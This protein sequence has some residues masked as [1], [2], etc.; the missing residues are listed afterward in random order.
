MK[1]FLPSLGVL[2]IPMLTQAQ[3]L[4]L[5]SVIQ[6]LNGTQRGHHLIQES[7]KV[8]KL[9]TSTELLEKL[10]WGEAS[11][12]DTVLT[13]HYN[14]V[15]GAEEREQR[16]KIFLKQ[17]QTYVEVALDFAHE[18]V[19]AT[20]PSL[21]DPYDPKLTAAQY[22][23]TAI[24][25][26]GGEVEAVMA[27]CEVGFELSQKEPFANQRCQHY[28][29]QQ[30]LSRDRVLKDFYQVGKWLSDL[31]LRLGNEM[32]ILPR[33]SSEDPL[34]YSSTAHSP[35]PYA[36]LKEFEAI[37]EMACKNSK[38]RMKTLHSDPLASGREVE[39]LSRRCGQLKIL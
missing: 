8:W 18:L 21:F 3:D 22:I 9:R 7:L 14:P 31:A 27:E 20:H 33:L 11:R 38:I 25:G 23:R 19:H 15:T 34:L 29:H 26:D 37:T 28:V 17:N 4:S 12:T 30:A 5:K 2:L 36:L 10:Q 24:E 16:V 13:R 6:V 1:G 32:S 39:F 35:Y